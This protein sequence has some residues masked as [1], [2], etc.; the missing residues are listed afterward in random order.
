MEIINCFEQV[1]GIKLNYSI[2]ERRKG[3]VE[4]I[5]ANCQFANNELSWEAKL[6]LEEMLLSAWEWEKRINSQKAN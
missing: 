4:K 2:R 1:T 6:N 3:D 5:Y